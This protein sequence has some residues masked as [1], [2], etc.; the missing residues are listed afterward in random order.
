M[1]GKQSYH[2][3]FVM[4][5]HLDRLTPGQI[6]L[7]PS[8]TRSDWKRRDLSQ[9][10]G[11]DAED[12]RFA[13][14]EMLCEM[15]G[16][17]TMRQAV[18]GLYHL[19]RFHAGVFEQARGIKRIWREKRDEIVN[20]IRRLQPAFGLARACR[21]LRVSVASFHRWSPGIAC[22][23]SPMTLCRKRHPLQISMPEQRAIETYTRNLEF[24]GWSLASIYWQMVRDAAAGFA[25]TT[26]YKYVRLLRIER[27]RYRKPRPRTGI[28]ASAPLR[29]LHMDVTIYRTMDQ[30]RAFIHLI[31]DNF[32]RAIL[33]W[34]VARSAN[35]YDAMENLRTV[36]EAHNLYGRELQLLT[37]DGSENE[38]HV[39]EFLA[40][41]GLR[42]QKLVAQVDIIFSNSMIEAVNKILKYQHLFPKRSQ[43]YSFEDLERALA[44]NI[45]CYNHRPLPALYGLRP[46]EVLNGLRPD[47]A[48]FAPQM[49]A[50][51]AARLL[52]N[53]NAVCPAC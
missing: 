42:I 34:R 17:K 27:P 51:R 2:P 37:D 4:L 48:R 49:A 45:E 39:T 31:I 13:A 24:A 12:P 33:V 50:A 7:I 30:T 47:P 32:S 21:L 40:R 52:A 20:V 19:Y 5:Y 53:R 9:A 22:P 29:L 28:R 38:G 3:V 35:S 10:A 36:C 6:A 14:V 1:S 11:F 8:S 18:K 26:F 16:V 23:S 41:P 46:F 15:S 43:I 25:L 44:A